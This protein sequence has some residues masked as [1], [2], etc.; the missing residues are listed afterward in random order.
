M[1]T[2]KYHKLLLKPYYKILKEIQG[3]YKTALIVSDRFTSYPLL[4]RPEIH[5]PI[6]ENKMGANAFYDKMLQR[7]TENNIQGEFSHEILSFLHEIGH[8]YTIKNKRQ[9]KS[10]ARKARL[11]QIIQALFFSNS[12]KMTQ[13]CYKKYFNLKA[14]KLADQWAMDYIK[15]NRE[16]V[17]K[18]QIMLRNNYKKI[19]PRLLQHY[20]NDLKINLLKV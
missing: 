11:I 13:W 20:E 16:Q 1:R 17:D 8:L 7:L 12:Y 10:Y 18:W 6:K 15:N 3:E 19:L 2:K 9:I 4:T 5:I 14:E